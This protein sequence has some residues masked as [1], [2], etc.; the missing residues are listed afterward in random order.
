[1]RE[2]RVK[3]LY[4]SG[5]GR[6]G[7]TV[8]GGVLGQIE[9]FFHGGELRH[10][11]DRGLIKNWLCGCGSPF[12]ECEFWEEVFTDAFGGM[13][14]VDASEMVRLRETSSRTHHAP[15][16]LT[17]SGERLVLKEHM[18]TYLEN[19]EKLY[20]SIHLS[21]G[22]RVIVDSSK[23]PSYAYALSKM[24]G[25]DLYVIHLTRDPRAVTYSWLRKRVQSGAGKNS[26]T[27]V[28][29]RQYTP[30][31]SV[32]RWGA[33]NLATEMLWKRSS[34]RYLA[35]RYEDFVARPQES[36]RSILDMVREDPLNSSPF[37]TSR[38]VK[39]GISHT[40]SGNPSRF[41]TGTIELRLDEEWRSKMRRGDRMLVTALTWPL[42]SR[43][44]YSS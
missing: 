4:I 27:P 35:L 31:G 33:R 11:W 3:V 5:F 39:M 44:G 36:I 41:Q 8:L 10:V 29:M 13:E 9:G 2:D 22:S 32:L 23:V 37:V 17:R 15:L 7:S 1:M 42:L 20:R 38:E 12:K 16:L 25:I 18:K 40:I 6:S 24:P 34:D 28:Y 43:Y 19:L 26:R 21:T 14:L 30:L